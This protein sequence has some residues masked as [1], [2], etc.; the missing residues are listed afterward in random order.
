MRPMNSQSRYLFGLP[1]GTVIL[2]GAAFAITAAIV[3]FQLYVRND[4]L[5]P[6]QLRIF[7]YLYLIFDY[8]AALLSI[9]VIF[10]GV[11]PPLQK[12]GA[13]AID[14]LGDHPLQTAAITFAGLAA[15]ALWIYHAHPLCMDEYAPYLQ[16]AAFAAGKI[17]GQ[18]PVELVDWLVVPGFQKVFLQVSH[19]TGAVASVYLPGFAL[20]LAPFRGLGVPWLLNPLI[21]ALS[22]LVIHRLALELFGTRRAAGAAVL[23]ALASPAFTIN[24]LSFYSMPAHLLCNG[25][26][27]LL[28][29]EPTPRRALA[30][31]LVGGLAINLHNP[32]PHA[33]FAAPWLI[34]LLCRADR[35]RTVP[36]IVTGYLPWLVVMFAWQHLLTS[37]A[38]VAPEPG[39]AGAASG[40]LQALLAKVQ[41]VLVAPSEGVIAVRLI[42]LSKL[43][44]WAV[45]TLLIVSAMG[46]WARRG[47]VRVRLLGWS[48]LLTLVGFLFIP[49]DQGHG[50][51]Y[52]Y[53]HSAWFVLPLLA[54]AAMT[55]APAG[56]RRDGED[57]S[58]ALSAYLGATA[59]ASAIVLTAYFSWQVEGFI[60]R[61]LGQLPVAHSGT[62]KVFIIDPT[63]GYYAADLV[64]NDPF[65]RGTIK[66][67]THGPE[68]DP[69]VIARHFP[70]LVK[71][72]AD[73]RGQVW[74]T[75]LAG[76]SAA[77]PN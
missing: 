22:V 1:A 24:A 44:I 37:M 28:L 42:G 35:S 71:L 20:L 58:G 2:A 34:W 74:G 32:F 60:V 5:M 55:P 33:L 73:Y 9:L 63:F 46:F 65:M 50:W 6:D 56:V 69:K 57:R 47:D 43:W 39:T 59:L 61:H 38:T 21:G 29:L 11:I 7:Y 36:A 67:V 17:T 41:K 45:P 53:F 14:A 23:L 25:V 26:F 4:V 40:V 68:Q 64:Q 10:A 75:P 48:T 13:A 31:G 70:G 62:P 27:V 12:L 72:G 30:A 49:F 52:R 16:S 3:L 15:G 19:Q 66:L 8:P 77:P 76:E 54:S 18:L 51:G